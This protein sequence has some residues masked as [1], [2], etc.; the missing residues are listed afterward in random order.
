MCPQAV[1]QT[2]WYQYSP[3]V[4]ECSPEAVRRYQAY[5]GMVL[6]RT[7]P[8]TYLL[9]GVKWGLILDIYRYLGRMFG[10][11]GHIGLN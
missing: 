4:P 7:G 3:V 2:Q 9:M 6:L 11:I 1:S 8:C 10:Y 5:P